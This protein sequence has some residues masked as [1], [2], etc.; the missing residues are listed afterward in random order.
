MPCV[1]WLHLKIIINYS[2]CSTILEFKGD[3]GW[4]TAVNSVKCVCSVI[5][6]EGLLLSKMALLSEFHKEWFRKCLHLN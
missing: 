2:L 3:F 6:I 1:I 5:E 4:E